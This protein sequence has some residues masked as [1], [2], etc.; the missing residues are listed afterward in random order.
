MFVAIT[1][2]GESKKSNTGWN[3]G[4][5]RVAITP[6]QSMW[7]AGYASRTKPAESK[8]HD[9]W[10]KA[11]FL[12]DSKGNKSLFITS[13]LIGFS[14]VLSDSIHDELKEKIGL[15]PSQIILNS[16][17]THSGPVL[18]DDLKNYYP[19]DAV[20]IKKRDDYSAWLVEK[21]V[22]IALEAKRNLQPANLFAQNGVVRFQV[23]RRNNQEAKITE[24]TDLK[25][26]NDFAVPVL[27][28]EDKRGRIKAIVFG[29]ACHPTVLNGYQWSGDYPGFAQ[30]ELEKKYKGA[31]A[32]FFQGAGADQNPLP[33]RSIPLAKQ[34]GKELAAAVERVL[35]EEMLS[36]TPCLETACSEVDIQFVN[37]PPTRKE[38]E[39]IIQNN[40]GYPDYLKLNAQFFLEKLKRGEK[41]MTS[42]PYPIH[43][44]KLGEQLIIALGGELL[45]GYAIKLKNVYGNNIFVL[46]YSN[47]VMAYIPTS[48]VLAEG[49]YEGTRSA[50]F[51]TPWSSD[52]E[53]VI[54]N[55]IS[56]LIDKIKER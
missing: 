39:Q 33:R 35:D 55:E 18:V 8:L 41:L 3:A 13:D 45:T 10:A 1:T 19:L 43:V 50:L 53:D 36:L 16:S 49:G 12:E 47:D 40:S 28:I 42:Y 25:G 14:K 37:A 52:I 15:S 56:Q 44:W 30:L 51:S 24:I 4:I 26:P 20:Q 23:N 11:L 32:M 5:A 17:H 6:E 46:G 9:L 38:L 7:M 29:Y 22:K 48:D 34:Y 21:I 2:F 31:T 27:K 54:I